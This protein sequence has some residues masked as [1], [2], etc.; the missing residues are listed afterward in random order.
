MATSNR[1]LAGF[2][3]SNHAYYES[4]FDLIQS[5]GRSYQINGSAL[6][7]GPFWG[8]AR[9]VWWIFWL[10]LALDV[11]ALS[12]FFQ[13]WTTEGVRSDFL[14]LSVAI[15]AV[16]RLAIAVMANRALLKKF[17]KWRLNDRAPSGLSFTR[18]IV[19]AFLALA[20]VPLTVYRTLRAVP[21]ER[22]CRGVLRDWRDGSTISEPLHL[23]DCLTISGV[24]VEKDASRAVA[25]AIDKG[26]DYLVINFSGLFDFIA[27]MVRTVLIG[28]ENLFIGVPWP[29]MIVLFLLASWRMAGPRVAIFTAAALSYLALMG[30]WQNAMATISLVFAAVTIAIVIGLPLGILAAKNARANSI[31]QPVLDLMQTLPSFVYLIPAIAFFSIGKTPAV[32]AT[33][34]Y[35]CPPLIR[36]TVLGIRQ[37]PAPVKEAAVAFGSTPMQLLVKTELPLA[38]PSIMTGVNQSIMMSLAMSVIAALIGAGGLGFDVLFALQQVQPGRGLLAG[39]AIALCAMIIDRSVQGMRRAGKH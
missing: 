30:F 10:G 27:W 7:A 15:F 17:E 14:A 36:L 5:K 22:E 21:S 35:A 37:V 12:I 26:V 23:L 38:M 29:V 1:D 16:S 19:G 18:V 34:I 25:A 6:L 8:A 24:P 33:V 32:L 20:I 2:V 28:L 3:S 9:A 31:V 39:I 11:C 4:A 13:A